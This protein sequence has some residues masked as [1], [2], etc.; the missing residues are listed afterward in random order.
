MGMFNKSVIIEDRFIY[1]TSSVA[2]IFKNEHYLRGK[3][4][5]CVYWRCVHETIQFSRFEISL[6]WIFIIS[7]SI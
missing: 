5:H 6:K 7:V 4:K 3:I 1:Q 2:C